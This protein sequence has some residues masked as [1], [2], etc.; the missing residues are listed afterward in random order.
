MIERGDGSLGIK[1]KCELLNIVRSTIYYQPKL[2]DNDDA[3]VMNEIRDIYQETPFYGYRK[4]TIR[5]RQKGFIVNR[6]RVQNLLTLAGIKAIYPVKK[7][8]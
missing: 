6:K 2:I 3:I 4:I 5:L 1:R 8:P 7:Q